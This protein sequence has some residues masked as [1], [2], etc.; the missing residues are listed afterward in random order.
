MVTV[1][2]IRKG[3]EAV[4]DA[5]RRERLRLWLE[6]DLPAWFEDR[7]LPV[8]LDVAQVWGQLRAEAGRPVSAID[9][10]IAATALCHGLRVVTRNEGDF[11]YPGLQIVNPWST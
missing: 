10:L 1:G 8:S 2:E 5:T 7:L 6:D 9:G 11:V 3:V 4:A